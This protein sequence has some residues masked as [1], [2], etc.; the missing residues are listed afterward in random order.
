[1]TVFF[2]AVQIAVGIGGQWLEASVVSSVLAIAAFTTGIVLGIF[3]LGIFTQ[4]VGQ[5]AALAALVVGLVGMSWVSFGTALAWPWFALVGAGGTY[6]VGWA[7]S[8]VWPREP[9][10]DG[11]PLAEPPMELA[12]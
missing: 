10:D 2:G 12:A 7:A 6:L 5:R 11:A 3:F 4:R 8:F 9:G 1:L